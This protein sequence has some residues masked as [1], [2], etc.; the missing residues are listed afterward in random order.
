MGLG[1]INIDK[2]D[3]KGIGEGV[4]SVFGGVGGLF[5][6]IRTAITGK[7][8]IDPNKA[9]EL[10]AKMLE[11]EAAMMAAQNNINAIQAASPSKFIAGARPAA[12]WVCVFGLAWQCIFFP[13]MTWIA[14]LFSPTFKP[15]VLDTATL[16]GL[17]FPLLGLGAYRTWEKMK[18]VQGEH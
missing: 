7:A 15:P 12:I 2:I 1:A 10:E 17:L 3:F 16:V 6:D 11:L 5:K 9:A 13:L 14:L 8:P 18:G 4:S